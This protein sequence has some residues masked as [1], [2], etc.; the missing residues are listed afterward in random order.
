MMTVKEVMEQFEAL[1]N[2]DPT[3]ADACVDT[4]F[5]HILNN[6]RNKWCNITYDEDIPKKS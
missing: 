1:I 3:W 5:I 2:E 6:K 4:D